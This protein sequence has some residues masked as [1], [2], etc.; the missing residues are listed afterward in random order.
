MA[1]EA[2]AQ[3]ADTGTGEGPALTAQSTPGGLQVSGLPAP[4]PPEAAPT[5]GG[6]KSVAP[7]QG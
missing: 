7:Q 5:N 3:Q 6:S 4:P 1:Q 2:Q